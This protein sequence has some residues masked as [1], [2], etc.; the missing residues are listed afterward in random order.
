MT[1][2]EPFDAR[3]TDITETLRRLADAGENAG[4]KWSERDVTRVRRAADAVSKVNDHLTFD[5]TLQR[6]TAFYEAA[7]IL[8]QVEP[9][10]EESRAKARLR[11]NLEFLN[12]W[13]GCDQEDI[14]REFVEGKIDMRRKCSQESRIGRVVRVFECRKN[15]YYRL[16]NNCHP[17]KAGSDD[18]CK[19]PNVEQSK[20]QPRS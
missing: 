20:C 13:V 12:T 4:R 17:L 10:V 9:L 14:E 11:R 7:V 2:R 16:Q 6:H 15:M 5:R 1:T 8:G 18:D 19:N 3:T